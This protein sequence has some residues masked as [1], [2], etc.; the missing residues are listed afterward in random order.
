MGFF[1][2]FL[3]PRI[4]KDRNSNKRSKSYNML[5]YTGDKE[6]SQLCYCHL[7]ENVPHGNPGANGLT[8]ISQKSK[9]TSI[10]FANHSTVF[11]FFLFSFS[12]LFLRWCS[13]SCKHNNSSVY[14]HL[15]PD[16]EPTGK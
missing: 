9:M 2:F 13:C 15:F 10:P 12:Q 1:F 14:W 16:L 4:R 7:E 3:S 6:I 8:E 11:F 5:L